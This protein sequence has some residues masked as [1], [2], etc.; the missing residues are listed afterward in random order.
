MGGLGKDSMLCFGCN[1]QVLWS[2]W[3]AHASV[4]HFNCSSCAGKDM[5]Y[6]EYYNHTVD[7]HGWGKEDN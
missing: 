4:S 3:R 7:V 5:T 1:T 2:D 6:T